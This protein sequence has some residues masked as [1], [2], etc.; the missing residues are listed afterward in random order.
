MKSI[1]DYLYQHARSKPLATA[2]EILTPTKQ[3]INYSQLA[4]KVDK[5]AAGLAQQAEPGERVILLYS[6]C[7]DFII[8]FLSCLKANLIPVPVYPPSLHPDRM[9]AQI[10]LLETIF[11]NAQPS[12]VLTEKKIKALLISYQIKR[13]LHQ[14][15]PFNNK[16]VPA[17]LFLF[18]YPIKTLQQFS[19]TP[20]NTSYSPLNDI[21]FLQYTSGST[22]DPKGVMISHQNILDNTCK[23]SAMLE[24]IENVVTWL[25]LYHDM[26]LMNGVFIP[27]FLGIPAHIL[28]PLAFISDP[29]QWLA[30]LSSYKKCASGGPNFAYEHSIKRITEEQ[31]KT[32][33]LSEWIVAYIGAEPNRHETLQRF[34]EHFSSTGFSQEKFYPCYGLAESTVG[35]CGKRSHGVHSSI[36]TLHINQAELQNGHIVI[37]PTKNQNSTTVISAGTWP[38]ED[39]V[40]TVD[41]QTLKPLQELQVGEIWCQNKSIGEG[42][43]RKPQATAHYFKAFTHHKKG[44]YLRTGDLGFIYNRELFITGRIKD[45]INIRGRNFS[46]EDIEWACTKCHPNVKQGGVC[47]FN[48]SE[49]LEQKLAIIIEV[50]LNPTDIEQLFKAIRNPLNI[51]FGLKASLLILVKPRTLEKTSSGKLRRGEYKKNTLL[52]KMPILAIQETNLEITRKAPEKEYFKYFTDDQK[53]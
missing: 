52:G 30:T 21:A 20:S 51:L 17:P 16:P 7:L 48:Y 49:N 31:K 37:E 36:F 18:N 22:G 32:L 12:L 41:P 8:A 38:D 46:A 13:K 24:S 6:S 14:V 5:H 15:W 26:G 39:H 42:Y 11:K 40:I 28:S 44:P 10:Q 34:T 9:A 2:F 25:P 3:S 53:D 45:V 47:A 27:L 33:D 35:V 23:V 19:K 43:W 29:Y 4:N 1:L 50:T